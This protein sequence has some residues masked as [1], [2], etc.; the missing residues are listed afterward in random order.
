MDKIDFVLP[1]VDSNDPQ[2]QHS[3]NH[4]RY[5]NSNHDANAEAR[6]RDMDTLKYALR[7]IETH[8]PWYHKIYLITE[9]HAPSWLNLSH[10]KIT[11]VTHKELF[12]DTSHLPVF[13][14]SAIEMNLANLQ[15]LSEKFVYMNDDFIIF[16]PVTQSRFFKEGKPVDFFSHHFLPRGRLF[17]LL[18]GRDTWIHS[19]NNNLS[20][21]NR[22]FAP[23]KPEKKYLFH[24]SYSLT[25]KANNFL[26][27][28][29]FQRLIWI[30]HW[31]HP[32]PML[33]Q[34]LHDVYNTF[35]DAIMQCSM[36]KFRSKQDLTQYIYRYW[37]L[38]KGNFYP[39]KHY[40]GLVA[41]LD[42]LT[43]LEEMI[44]TLETDQSIRFVC[45]N[46]SVD[47]SDEAYRKVK[48]R[49]VS[50]LKK[51]FPQKASFER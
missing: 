47:L 15:G 43:I 35:S 20:L 26:L 18:K 31:H 50:F 5:G 37:Q 40:D 51:R 11:L 7:A 2:W 22:E 45:F 6:F 34:T 28:Y 25:D 17:E 14:S 19:L 48:E 24:P 3:R 29:L 42:S 21:L 10:E 13:N 27:R 9:G 49:L 8:C 36:N 4:H 44:E 16:N 46:D 39:Y 1:W 32:Q 41:N 38:I 12:I 23:I 33:K 30:N